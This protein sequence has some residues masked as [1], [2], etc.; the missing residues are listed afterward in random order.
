MGDLEFGEGELS[1]DDPEVVA[2]MTRLV[3]LRAGETS[4]PEVGIPRG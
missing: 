1:D 3:A 4:V 2:G